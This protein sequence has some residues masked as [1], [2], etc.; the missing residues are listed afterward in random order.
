[1]ARCGL[2]SFLN[3]WTSRLSCFHLCIDDEDG[4]VCCP[5]GGL[6]AFH[7]H[8]LRC[9][10]C[11]AHARRVQ[12]RHRHAVQV[13]ACVSGWPLTKQT[14]WDATVL[15]A[16]DQGRHAGFELGMLKHVARVDRV[17]R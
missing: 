14:A 2:P 16:A 1:M 8:T 7:A 17:S 9:I 12:K 11:L 13:D 4:D 15:L 10:G 3:T 5:R 6:R